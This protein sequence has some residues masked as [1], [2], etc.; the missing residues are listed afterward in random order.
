MQHFMVKWLCCQLCMCVCVQVLSMFFCGYFELSIYQ[1][2]QWQ[3]NQSN[4]VIQFSGFFGLRCT[5]QLAFKYSY[6]CDNL[7]IIFVLLFLNRYIST[8]INVQERDPKAHRFLGLLYEVEENIDK[9]V[10]CYKVNHIML[11][12]SPLHKNIMPIII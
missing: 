2:K 7:K 9:A 10:E 6:K 8:Y 3:S 1:S 12:Y 5:L 11:K 4:D